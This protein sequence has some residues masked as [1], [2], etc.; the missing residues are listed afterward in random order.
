[1]GD[2]EQASRPG[3]RQAGVALTCAAWGTVTGNAATSEPTGWTIAIVGIYVGIIATVGAAA[4][5][6]TRSGTTE[7]RSAGRTL[8]RMTTMAVAAI[9]AGAGLGLLGLPIPAGGGETLFLAGLAG[10]A[11]WRPWR[12]L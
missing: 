9:T 12:G 2:T 10:M 7:A 5:R 1:M 8:R 4:H 11:L 3:R 6:T